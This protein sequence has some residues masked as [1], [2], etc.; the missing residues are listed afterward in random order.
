[1]SHPSEAELEQLGQISDELREV[2]AERGY[3]VD[4]AMDVDSAF[5]SGNARAAMMRDLAID[6]FRFFGA[7]TSRRYRFRKAQ[8]TADGEFVVSAS[9]DS[10]LSSADEVPGLFPDEQW[11]FI[12]TASAEG[13]I[14]YT[15]VAKVHG[16]VVGKPGHL[17][18]GPAIYIGGVEPTTGGFL[19]ADEDDLEGF[20]DDESGEGDVA[21][22]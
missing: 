19:P 15:A 16:Y 13:L 9:L 21:S 10:A 2:F 20:D 7:G 1:M 3:R 14:E 18:L 22:L 12:W 6:A 11:I 17:E 5:G 8:R 4:V